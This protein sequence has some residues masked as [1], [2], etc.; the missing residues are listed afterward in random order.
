[1]E[2]EDEFLNTFFTYVTQMYYDKAK[3]LVVYSCF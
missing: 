1:M 3:E 2:H